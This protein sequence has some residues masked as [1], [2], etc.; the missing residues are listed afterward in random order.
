MACLAMSLRNLTTDQFALLEFKDRILDPHHVLANNWTTSSSVCDW[1]GVS[2][3]VNHRRVIS[4]DLS[5]MS[6]IGTIPPHLGNLSFLVYLNM[7]S[8]DFHGH[9]PKE[10]RQLRRLRL[11]DLR[12]NSLDGEIPSWFGNLHK[13]ETLRI[14]NNFS[15]TIPPTLGNM[16]NLQILDFQSNQLFGSIPSTIY[17]ISSLQT[18]ALTFNRLSDSIKDRS[19]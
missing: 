5:K 18:I 16:S 10:L 13:V 17:N 7:S 1:F 14:G 19:M 8:N 4:L 6:F 3:G 2:C 15:G 9:L 11:I 12:F